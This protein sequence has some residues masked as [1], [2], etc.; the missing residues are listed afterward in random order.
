MS[1]KLQLNGQVWIVS[2]GKKPVAEIHLDYLDQVD[3]IVLY[4]DSSDNTQLSVLRLAAS[5]AQQFV[6]NR[7]TPAMGGLMVA[8][9]RNHNLTASDSRRLMD[10]GLIPDEIQKLDR[11]TI[12]KHLRPIRVDVIVAVHKTADEALQAAVFQVGHPSLRYSLI[13]QRTIFDNEVGLQFTVAKPDRFIFWH[14][15]WVPT[16]NDHLHIVPSYHP[17]MNGWESVGM[18]NGDTDAYIRGNAVRS[19]YCPKAAQSDRHSNNNFGSSW[20]NVKHPFYA[21][22]RSMSVRLITTK[23]RSREGVEE[24][25]ELLRAA[26]GQGKR[27]VEISGGFR[28]PMK[29]AHNRLLELGQR[30]PWPQADHSG[31]GHVARGSEEYCVWG[32]RTLEAEGTLEKAHVPPWFLQEGWL[33]IYE[34]AEVRPTLF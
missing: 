2:K 22:G 27:Y 23:L 11:E 15:E 25:V 8:E 13:P 4:A 5:H 20:K 29:C 6:K 7:R 10:F 26:L 28:A 33:K 17:V 30:S 9:Y 19:I 32:Y 14:S 18:V 1:F 12:V 34:G 31:H 24:L 3:E 16:H 21:T